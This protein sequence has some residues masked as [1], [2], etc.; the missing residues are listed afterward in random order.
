MG[1]LVTNANPQDLPEGASPRCFDVD[2]VTGSVFTRPGLQSVY[3]YASTLVITS[4]VAYNGIGTFGYI[5]KAPLVNE[6][7][8]LE[9]FTGSTSYLNGIE[10][11]VIAVNDADNTFTA[12]VPK[13]D[14][15][16]YSGLDARAI[17]TV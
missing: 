11:S 15:G 16:P 8:I 10:I 1:G 17:S 6:T 7:F 2:F 12:A 9:G 3:T 13:E 14:D 4:Y 5:G